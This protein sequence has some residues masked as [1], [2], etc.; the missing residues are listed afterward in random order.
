MELTNRDR[1]LAVMSGESM[2]RA[3]L[4]DFMGNCN[5]ASCLTRWNREGLAPDATFTDVRRTVGFD[6]IR[7]AFLR[8]KSFIWPEAATSRASTT[9]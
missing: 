4:F 6:A 7:G 3:P 8:V 2:D 9:A 5:W 1:F